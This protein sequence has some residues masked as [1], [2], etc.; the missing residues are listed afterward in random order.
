MLAL[1]GPLGAGKT[2]FAKGIAKGL[3]VQE[4]VTSPTFTIVSE[5][6]G[7]LSL[8]HADLYRIGSAEELE[9]LGF[10]DLISNEGV[11]II[12]WPEKA[13]KLPADAIRVSL[14]ICED[15]TRRITVEGAD[16]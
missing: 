16:A 6:S 14:S 8:W 5:Y 15:D 13:S 2:A 3:A 11:T 7:R 4:E 9:L 10:D 12:E 1:S